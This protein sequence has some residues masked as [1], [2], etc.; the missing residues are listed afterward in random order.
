MD[1]NARVYVAGATTLIGGALVRTLAARGSFAMIGDPDPA[2][3]D[4]ASVDRFFARTR[5]D[6][7][8]VAAGRT[9]GIAGNE[10]A[11]ADLMIDN[12]LVAGHLVPAAWRH[13]VSKLLYL[14]SSC[15]YPRLAPQPLQVSSLWTGAL[16]PTSAAYATAKLAGITLCEAFRLQHGARFIPAIGAD[17]YGPGDDF[18]PD[19]AHVVGA[20]IRRIHDAHAALRPSVDVWGSGEPRREFI[21]VDDLADACAFVMREYEGK[22]PINLG[23]GVVSS[24]AELAEEICRIVGYGGQ[25]RFDRRRLD[26]MPF[27]GLDTTP[28]RALGWTPRWDLRRGLTKTYEWFRASLA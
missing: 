24:I 4:P 12:L 10:R 14:A 20:L 6:Y 26:G 8:F 9:A 16:E 19:N 5:P 11:P 21:Y 13:G 23:T 15:V 17:V 22:E 27:K 18:T 3:D 28:L 2:F 25:L 7:V 1:T